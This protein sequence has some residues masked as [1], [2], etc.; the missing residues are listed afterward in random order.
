MESNPDALAEGSLRLCARE[1]LALKLEAL[2]TDLRRVGTRGFELSTSF[3]DIADWSLAVRPTACLEGFVMDHP[4]LG[5]G[6]VTT[7]EL[8]YFDKK[9]GIAR[10]L[11]RWYRLGRPSQPVK[12]DFTF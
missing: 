12:M 8:Y 3:I 11:S 6:R 10:T 4:T 2:A 7:S 1:E 5:T 9:A